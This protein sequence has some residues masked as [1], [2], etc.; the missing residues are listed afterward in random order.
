MFG[1]GMFD[2]TSLGDFSANMTV[3]QVE[4]TT[5]CKLVWDEPVPITTTGQQM[6]EL[7]GAPKFGMAQIWRNDV[8]DYDPSKPDDTGAVVEFW[9][10]PSTLIYPLWQDAFHE[11]QESATDW[12]EGYRGTVVEYNQS[13]KFTL[14]LWLYFTDTSTKENIIKYVIDTYTYYQPKQSASWGSEDRKLLFIPWQE[15]RDEN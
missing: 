10:Y 14:K 9:E 2:Q 15:R 1:V 3:Q 6:I 13:L 5:M 7:Y 8:K 4:Q 12:D 11:W